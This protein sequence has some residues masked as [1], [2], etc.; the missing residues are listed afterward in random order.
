MDV[1]TTPTPTTPHRLSDQ[2]QAPHQ[3]IHSRIPGQAK[4]QL[5]PFPPVSRR[6]SIG[7]ES[8]LRTPLPSGRGH[9]KPPNAI[10]PGI[11]S[12]TG[13]L[14]STAARIINS[15]NPYRNRY[16]VVQVMILVWSNDTGQ[17]IQDAIDDLVALLEK[18]YNYTVDIKT[19]PI[20][21]Q[22]PFRWLL[23]TVTQFVNNR[24]LRDTLKILYY[25]GYSYLDA[26]RE[27]VL[28]RYVLF[29]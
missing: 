18:K 28:S 2:Q 4:V 20:G 3:Q 23:Q 14:Q 5:S 19:I 17:E 24:D 25:T 10:L 8:R 7:N 6:L 15:A 26:D 9:E 27:M 22:S 1:D 21:A 13:D 11:E 12:F 16:D 29:F